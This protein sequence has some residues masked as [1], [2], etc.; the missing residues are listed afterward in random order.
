MVTMVVTLAGSLFVLIAACDL[1]GQVGTAI[2]A[3]ES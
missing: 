2:R 1:M 3:G